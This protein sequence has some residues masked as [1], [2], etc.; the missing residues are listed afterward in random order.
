MS[1]VN[2]T[3]IL[4]NEKYDERREMLADL[5]YFFKNLMKEIDKIKIIEIKSSETQNFETKIENDIILCIVSAYNSYI[6]LMSDKVNMKM[7]TNPNDLF[8]SPK[9][10][11]DF[12]KFITD[13]IKSEMNLNVNGNILEDDRLQ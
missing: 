5:Y 13:H 3:K 10:K 8:L 11:Q 1:N 6:E 7:I 9:E 4:K 2:K 12:V